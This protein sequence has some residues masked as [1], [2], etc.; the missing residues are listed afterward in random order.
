MTIIKIKNLTKKFN[1]VKAID[2]LSFDIYKGTILG[3]I[4]PNGS[5]KST[6]TNVL[7]GMFGFDKGAIVI[8][9]K[10]FIKI[11]THHVFLNG[12]TRTFQ[13]IRLSEQMTV[14][15]N[16]LVVLGKK[17][18]V[19]A[20]FSRH[21]KADVKKAKELLLKVGLS[22]KH[23]QLVRELSYGQRKLLEIV[24]ALA[25]D[26]DIYLFDEPFAGLFPEMVE[27]VKKI[28]KELKKE[29]KAVVL[30]EHNM[31][32]IRELSDEVMVMDSGRLLAQGNPDTVLNNKEVI[33]AYIG[34]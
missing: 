18:V 6:L 32:I 16:I 11:K 1:G 24:R 10:K 29:N 22:H 12:V 25:M 7:T 31:A 9:N 19:R 2:D 20:L 34:D 17:N 5:G 13:N 26:V 33:E 8:N 4:G 21:T 30:I 14:M 23:N 27:V 15:D 28:L 3:V